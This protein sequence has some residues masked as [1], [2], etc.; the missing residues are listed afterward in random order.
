[1]VTFE[2]TLTM[3]RKFS[4][5]RLL[6]KLFKGSQIFRRISIN[7]ALGVTLKQRPEMASVSR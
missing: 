4:P 7:V 1:M 2:I 6:S 3:E 5:K